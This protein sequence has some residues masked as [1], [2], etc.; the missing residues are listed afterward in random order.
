ME[1]L[2]GHRGAAGLRQCMPTSIVRR[3]TL[4]RRQALH[5]DV[6]TQ[7]SSLHSSVGRAAF[8]IFGSVVVNFTPGKYD[9]FYQVGPGRPTLLHRFGQFTAS[10]DI[11]FREADSGLQHTRLI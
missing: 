2:R 3:P 4:L 7:T 11:V 8:C 10:G 6:H 1:P 5:A 9:F